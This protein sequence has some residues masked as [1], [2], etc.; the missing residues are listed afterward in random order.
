MCKLSTTNSYLNANANAMVQEL[1]DVIQKPA[2]VMQSI[3]LAIPG[4]AT[5]PVR[6]MRVMVIAITTVTV[7]LA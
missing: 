2:L 1:L 6:A 4:I 7:L 5:L 3:H